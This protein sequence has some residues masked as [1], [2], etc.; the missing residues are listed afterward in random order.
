MDDLFD[1]GGINLMRAGLRARN[2]VIYIG[3]D[4]WCAVITH[5]VDR[6]R[7]W[8]N[9]VSSSTP[10]A[11]STPPLPPAR[12]RRPST[13]TF[14]CFLPMPLFLYEYTTPPVHRPLM[15][16]DAQYIGI[17]CVREIAAAGP[18][19][20]NTMRSNGVPRLISAAFDKFGGTDQKLRQQAVTALRCMSKTSAHVE[21]ESD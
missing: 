12:A 17:A 11:P 9:F 20:A 19:P 15:N 5:K 3:I 21:C 8:N 1:D 14:H 16:R 4:S 6:A 13:T 18:V 7:R 2:A 10:R